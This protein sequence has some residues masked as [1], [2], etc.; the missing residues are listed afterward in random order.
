MTAVGKV[1]EETLTFEFEHRFALLI[2]K[3]QA[4]FKYVPPAN[5][6]FTYRNNGTLSDLTVDVTAKNVKLNNVTPCKM[7][8]GSFRAIVLPTKTATAIASGSYSITDVST[9]GTSTDKTLTYSFTPS[10]AFTAG[11]C[12]TLEVKSP[13]SAIEKTRE[14]TPGDFVFFTANNK[15]EIFLEMESLRGNTIPD[16][17]RCCRDGNYLRSGKNDRS[18]MQ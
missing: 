13:L 10:T 12:Y 15:I 18:G 7:D 5:A 11:C 3:P 9:S 2:L 17:Q 6:V 14:L 16:S 8:D 1:S 4:H